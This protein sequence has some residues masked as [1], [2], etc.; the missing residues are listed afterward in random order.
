M[1]NSSVKPE[2]PAAR[3]IV[4]S[5]HR[6][7]LLLCYY[8]PVMRQLRAQVGLEPVPGASTRA[9]LATGWARR[10]PLARPVR[11][12][13]SGAGVLCHIMSRENENRLIW[14]AQACSRGVP[15]RQPQRCS[16]RRGRLHSSLPQPQC[17]AADCGSSLPRQAYSSDYKGIIPR[18]SAESFFDLD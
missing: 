9:Y 7:F 17:P 1:S 5:C 10:T 16:W 18:M 15:S 6:V 8:M 2:Y 4:R 12:T 14:L 11:R 3:S 13:V